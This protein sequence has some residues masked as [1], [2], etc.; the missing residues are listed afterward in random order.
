VIETVPSTR[1]NPIIAEIYHR[2]DYIERRGSG[3]KKIRLE[4]S[5]LHGYT[6]EY[7]PEFRSTPTTFHVIFKNMN[8]DLHGATGQVARQVAGQDNRAASLIAF[9]V[10]PRTKKEMQEFIGIASR[11]HFEK[12][13]LK[14][15]LEIGEL[16]M[17]LPNKPNSRNQ[18][19]IKT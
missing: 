4:T 14:P 18:K 6:E 9:C 19:Y 11:E 7:A 3:L 10:S 12:A 5:Y 17:T 2:L 13:L 8:Y 16:R 1:R 15:L